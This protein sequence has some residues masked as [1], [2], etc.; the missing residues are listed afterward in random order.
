M[1]YVLSKPS[2]FLSKFIK[3]YWTFDSCI[4][5][6]QTHI[7][8]IV[9]SGL[10]EL[11]F[12]LGDKPVSVSDSKSINE[13]TV[14][15]GHLGEFYDI[16]VTGQLSLFSIIFKPHGLSAF[17]DI[18]LNSFYDR[19]VSLRDIIKHEADEL[20]TRLI[21]AGSFSERK[22]IIESYL[23]RRLKNNDNSLE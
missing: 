14:I 8:R 23:F 6:G 9:P 16:Q 4:P 7:Q 18:P 20:E 22:S 5:S 11:I 12:Y 15:T 19:N 3:H 13:K 10:L 21:E 17:F 2:I 1:E